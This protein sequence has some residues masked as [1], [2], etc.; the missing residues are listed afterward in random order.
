M[1]VADNKTLF[2]GSYSSKYSRVEAFNFTFTLFFS[3]SKQGS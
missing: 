2:V 3:P 1:H